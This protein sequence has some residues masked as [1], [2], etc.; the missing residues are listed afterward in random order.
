[1]SDDIDFQTWICPKCF[2]DHFMNAECTPFEQK[3]FMPHE[4]DHSMI[5]EKY[6]ELRQDA[7]KLKDAL[8][9]VMC[10]GHSELCKVMKPYRENYLCSFEIAENALKEWNQ[11][12][13]N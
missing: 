10:E 11:K 12:H 13:E 2:D 1:M 3:E 8:H 4:S 5:A 6:R 7:Q 9:D